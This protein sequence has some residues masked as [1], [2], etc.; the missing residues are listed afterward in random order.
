MYNKNL[1]IFP[2]GNIEG[3]TPDPIPNSEVKPFRADGTSLET[4][5]ESRTLPG[6]KLPPS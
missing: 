6:F 2:G 3:A 4:D 5:W 1:N